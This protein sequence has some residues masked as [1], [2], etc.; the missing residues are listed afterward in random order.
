MML[1]ART[2]PDAPKHRG[3]SFLLL[4]MDDPGITVN[5]II[6]MADAH[7]FNMITFDDVRVH[8]ENL[9]GE[10]N[11]GWYVGATLLDLRAL[12]SRV[13]GLGPAHSGRPDRVL[14]GEH[15]QRPTVGR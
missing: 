11:R 3:I 10:L 14:R 12:G 4:D 6:N 2:D 8:K 15:P 9:V 5:P 13:L 7:S 1:L